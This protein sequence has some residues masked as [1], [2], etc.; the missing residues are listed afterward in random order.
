MLGHQPR[1]RR[2]GCRTA[3]IAHPLVP[4]VDLLAQYRYLG[5]TG[6]LVVQTDNDPN[7]DPTYDS[8]GQTSQL[9]F[10]TP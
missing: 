10:V 3:S 9:Y 4:G 8:L 2:G 1:R 5:F 7:A 6:S